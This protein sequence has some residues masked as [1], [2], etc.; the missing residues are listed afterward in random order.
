LSADRLPVLE[1]V[2]QAGMSDPSA[3]RWQCHFAEK[4]VDILLRDPSRRLGKA[5]VP[6]ETVHWVIALTCAEPTGTATHWIGRAMTK[7]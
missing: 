1:I 3:W 2:P 5:P 4:G 7:A 6:Q